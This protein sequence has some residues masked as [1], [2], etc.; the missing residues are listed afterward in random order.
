VVLDVDGTTFADT[1]TIERD[2]SAPSDVAARYWEF[3]S[4]EQTRSQR[5]KATH[6]KEE[7]G[8]TRKEL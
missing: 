1:L 3:E 8:R 2:P 7:L 4:Q 5:L 6:L